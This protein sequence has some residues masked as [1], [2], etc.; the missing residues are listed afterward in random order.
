MSKTDDTFAK[1]TAAIIERIEA[2]QAGNWS[3]PWLDLGEGIATNAV[4][5]KPYSGGNVLIAWVAA[6]ENRWDA[7]WWATYKQ[8][9]SVGAQVR[10]GSKGTTLVK[11]VVRQCKHST[12]ERCDRCGSMFPTTFTVFH[13]EQVDGWEQPEPTVRDTP[14]RVAEAD[15]FFT[16]VGA[17]VTEGG[18]RACYMPGTD[19]I[20]M[21]TLS[22]FADATGYYST[23][24]HEHGHW[25]GH[26]DRL[27]RDLTG[28]FGD[29]SYAMEELVA[30]LSAAF[31]CGH[32]GLSSVPRPD[33][34]AYLAN[35][36][37][38]LREDGKALWRAAS[39]A[40]QACDF[41]TKLVAAEDERLVAA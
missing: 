11:W 8:W 22:Q 6:M 14:E 15:R 18:D 17:D 40:Q 10:K 36:L 32:L 34:A 1:L 9:E 21:P 20:L 25:T 39:L 5:G 19:R 3:K 35:W 23:L 2:G 28:R 16:A 12:A 41:L 30:E 13:C 27:A 29:E 24:A 33:H 31:L 4:T 37:R 7:P 26:K 38:V